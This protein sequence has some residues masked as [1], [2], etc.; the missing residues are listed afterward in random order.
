MIGAGVFGKEAH[1]KTGFSLGVS[2]LVLRDGKV[3][4]IRRMHQPNRGKWTLPGGYVDRQE[5]LP[6]AAKR[7]ILEETGV[8]AEVVGAIGI[9]QRVSEGDNNLV[10]TFL[11]KWK[12]GEPRADQVEV[13][14]AEFLS[15]EEIL[16]NPDVIELTKLS[17]AGIPRA[18]ACVM[19]VR[20]CPPTPGMDI[21]HYLVFLP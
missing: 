15:L 21:S 8:E 19:L 3:L 1:L 11:M 6:D 7:E 4:V 20:P 10:I 12:A 13:D 9:R 16:E 5:S 14:G 18:A 2:G 17:V